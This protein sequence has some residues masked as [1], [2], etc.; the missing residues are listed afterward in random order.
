[1]KNIL[2]IIGTRP[3]AIK[4]CPLAIELKKF[5]KINLYICNT[6]QHSKMID[7]VFNVF[8]LKPDFNLKVMSKDQTLASLSS[9]LLNKLDNLINK[10][11][12]DLVLVHGDTT[13][14]FVGSLIAFYQKIKI[15]HVEAGLRT[16]DIHSP[17]P[18]E[19]NRVLT[20]KLADLH[21]APSRLS[22]MNL[23][24]EG[25][26]K[27]KIFITGNTVIDSLKIISR[28]INQNNKIKLSLNK[29][30]KFINF[31][32][33]I[34]LVTAHRRENFG[35]GFKQICKAISSISKRTDVEI[36]YPVHLNPNVIIPVKKMLNNK[37]IHLL[38]PLNYV[39][40]IY[41]MIKSNLILTD[42]GGVQ[43][44]S[45]YFN[46]NI[47]IMRDKT[48]R[49]ELKYN[50]NI[51]IVGSN[52]LKIEKY[53]NK[54]LDFNVKIKKSNHSKSPYGQGNASKKIAKIIFLNLLKKNN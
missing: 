28:N 18:E 1:M 33:K 8:E 39:E 21:F 48:E 52:S 29:Q 6:G 26:N 32:K 17:W 53:A 36:I 3:E 5:S 20:A 41:L 4:M 49:I 37:N 11:K 35:E 14:C 51:K 47:I 13:T 50:T 25:V 10:L 23:I 15:G 2:I 22:K 46:K 40:F 54:F 12:I 30:F 16:F 24:K 27:N 19:M 9:K 34:I 44:E 31:N 38:E 7:S 45:S 43:E 42:S